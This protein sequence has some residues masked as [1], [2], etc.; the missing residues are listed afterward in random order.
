MLHFFQAQHLDPQQ[1]MLVEEEVEV[2]INHPHHN[3]EL[4]EQVEEQMQEHL[5][6]LLHLKMELQILVVEAG[7]I[8]IHQR[9][10]ELAE[11]V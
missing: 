9:E 7:Q 4:V 10:L 3:K 6:H 5:E 2:P 1:E 11:V 8:V